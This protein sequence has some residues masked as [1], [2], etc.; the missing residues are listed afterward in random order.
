MNTSTFRSFVTVAEE[1]SFRAAAR[2]LNISQSALS[3]Q[4]ISLEQEL[5]APLFERLPRGIALTSAGELFLRHARQSISNLDLVKSD[6]GSLRGLRRGVVR[7][8]APESF[9]HFV[10]PDCLNELRRTYPGV[11]AEIRLN[12]TN[13]VIEDVREGRVDFG[14]AYNPELDSEMLASYSVREKIV[15]IMRPDHHLATRKSLVIGDLVG[16]P[17][18]LPLSDSATG[19]MIQKAASRYG[20]TLRKALETSSVHLRV[21]MTLQSDLVGVV[22]YLTAWEMISERKLVA[23][24]MREKSFDQGSIALF[25]LRGRRLSV[26]AETL[27]KMVHRDLQAVDFSG[28]IST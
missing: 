22:A 25:S 15:G 21:S 18:A 11:D 6:I 14:I 17:L 8:A 16:V 7:V 20:V 23:V 12:T 27:Q 3:R 2:I 1:G 4:I 13:G 19:V 10:L 9:M 24:P 28:R 5:D 26:A